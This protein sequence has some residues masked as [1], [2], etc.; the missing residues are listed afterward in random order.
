MSWTVFTDS[1]PIARKDY[2]CNAYYFLSQ[3]NESDFDSDDLLI[4]QAAKADKFM[5]KKGTKYVKRVGKFDG[6]W[7]TFRGR[8]DLNDLCIKYDLYSDY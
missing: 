1:E 3:L 7:Q 5:I 6:E 8:I 4:Y 2:K